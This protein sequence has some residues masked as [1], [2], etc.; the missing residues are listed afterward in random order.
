MGASRP[1]RSW[2]R[3]LH[4]R[5]SEL[6][7]SRSRTRQRQRRLFGDNLLRPVPLCHPISLCC[8]RSMSLWRPLPSLVRRRPRGAGQRHPPPPS[9]GP[10]RYAKTSHMGTRCGPV[11]KQRLTPKR[12]Y[13]SKA[14]P[15]PT[16]PIAELGQVRRKEVPVL[17]RTRV[18]RR[19]QRTCQ[20]GPLGSTGHGG[21]PSMILAPWLVSRTVASR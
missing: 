16:A 6:R 13:L 11:M 18:G 4:R 10:R 2:L 15:S 3:L 7:C 14:S 5:W 17:T 12:V 19:R 21:P 20:C 9:H 1:Q 8:L